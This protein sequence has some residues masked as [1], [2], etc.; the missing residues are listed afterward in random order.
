MARKKELKKGFYV[1]YIPTGRL[2]ELQQ[3]ANNFPHINDKTIAL[4]KYVEQFSSIVERCWNTEKEFVGVSQRVQKKVVKMDNVLTKRILDDLLAHNFLAIDKSTFEMGVKAYSYKPIYTTLSRFI[5]YKKFLNKKTDERFS[6]KHSNELDDDCKIYESVVTKLKFD[7]NIFNVINDNYDNDIYSIDNEILNDN[8]N[9]NLYMLLCTCSVPYEVIPEKM[10]TEL[11]AV[12]KILSIGVK[13]SPRKNSAGR[14]YTTLTN[15]PRI[16]RPFLRLNGKPL[17]GFDIA[18]SQPLIA[19]IVFR[20]YSERT[21]D[22]IKDDVLQYQAACEDGLFYEY[23]MKLNNVDTTCDD[24]RTKFKAE[25]FGKVFY[26]KEVEKENY[27]KTQFKEKYPTCYEAI[28]NI[29]GGL[30]S[31]EYKMFPVM[32]TEIETAIMFQTNI[33][34]I[35][36]GYDVVNIFDSLY[37][38]SE[39]AIAKAKRIVI[40]KFNEVGICPKLKDINYTDK[41]VTSIAIKKYE[42]PIRQSMDKKKTKATKLNNLQVKESDVVDSAVLFHTQQDLYIE[43]YYED[44]AVYKHTLRYFADKYGKDEADFWYKDEIE[45]IE[46][47]RK[48]QNDKGYQS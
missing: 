45:Q 27:L 47:Y 40:E 13:V 17:I 16:Y 10:P 19:S 35:K 5:I 14:V 39:E 4:Y 46:A 24:T 29:K 44:I 21:Y 22:C 28:F 41:V 12:N 30:Y 11:I 8:T 3:L 26:T 7:S 9:P 42:K 20:M 2:E 38:D 48:Q 32:M 23:F 33:E 36:M 25:F 43:K 1:K 6:E 34:V 18:N 31:K 15:L 37:S